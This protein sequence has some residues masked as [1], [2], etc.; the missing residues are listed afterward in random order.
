MEFFRRFNSLA[1]RRRLS[2]LGKET[3]PI[4]CVCTNGEETGDSVIGRRL[5]SLNTCV[6]QEKTNFVKIFLPFL[7]LYI[8]FYCQ[9]IS[10][11]TIIDYHPHTK[12]KPELVLTADKG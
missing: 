5:W 6:L 7:S 12:G 2:F 11:A 9:I 1:E 10:S 4:P 8:M 3:P